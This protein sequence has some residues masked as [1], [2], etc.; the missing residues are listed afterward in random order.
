MTGSD[1]PFAALIGGFMRPV[2]LDLGAI[3]AGTGIRAA[4]FDPALDDL[5]QRLGA[6]AAQA[7]LPPFRAGAP[8]PAVARLYDETPD[9][10]PRHR[11]EAFVQPLADADGAA[12]RSAWPVLH[13]SLARTCRNAVDNL[14]R[15]ARHLAGVPPSWRDLFAIAEPAREL[16]EVVTGLSDPHAGGRTVIRATFESGRRIAYKPRS[17]AAEQAFSRLL[18]ELSVDGRVPDQRAPRVLDAGD[19]GWMEWIE[20][21]PL[22]G[23]AEARS[24]MRRCGGLLAVLHIL[25]GGDIHPDNLLAAG[26]FPVIVD[27]ECLF[28]PS[29]GDLGCIDPLDDPVLFTS[30]IL[31]VFTS[32]DGGANFVPVAGGGAGRPPASPESIVVLANTDWMHLRNRL[33][34]SFPPG[35]VLD[36][37]SLDM[38]DFGA[39]IAAGYD[40]TMAALL[41]RRH[42]LLAEGGA[43]A[44]FRAVPCRM[45]CAPTNLYALVLR[46][47]LAGDASRDI[48]ALAL[49]AGR[50]AGRP[51]L[52]ADR[53]AWQAV[54]DAEKQAMMR[55]DVPAFTFLPDGLTLRSAEGQTIGNV[56]EAPMFDRAAATFMAL[57]ADAAR[58]GAALLEAAL[59]RPP[60]TEQLPAGDGGPRAAPLPRDVLR[61]L[62]DRVASL[63][64]QQGGDA[65]TWIRL[66]EQI[67]APVAPAGPG[68]C[69]GASGTAVFLAEAAGPLDDPQLSALARK[70][71]A[72]LRHAIRRGESGRLARNFGP[73]YGRGIG[74]MIAALGWCGRLLDDPRVIADGLELATASATALDAAPGMADVMDGA[75]GLAL[76]LGALAAGKVDRSHLTDALRLCGDAILAASRVEAQALRHWPER[77]K[78]GLTGLSH[79]TS[80]IAA[81]LMHVHAATADVVWVEAALEALAYEDAQHDPA[82]GTWH[83]GEKRRTAAHG[84]SSWCHG[85]PGIALA[86]SVLAAADSRVAPIRSGMLAALE[87]ARLHPIGDVDDLCCGEAGR[88]ECLAVAAGD[89]PALLQDIDAAIASRL[90]DWSSGRM[91]SLTASAPG[92]PEDASLLRGLAG[93]GHLLVRRIAPAF[94]CPVLMPPPA[95]L[96][97]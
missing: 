25:R 92:A 4:A 89:D 29:P 87:T 69:Y 30:G 91:R 58:S 96:I 51:A 63:A 1:I 39:D 40:A 70:A 61:S 21:E 78:P 76:G 13:D 35:P 82:A 22:A 83:G 32:F 68:L 11:Y 12:L 62:A 54:L 66:W 41:D 56:F 88:L 3:C 53:Q 37:E 27:L 28:Q 84:L 38:R 49:R 72:P 18:A 44:A 80:G 24:F 86:R 17:L 93:P 43:V 95:A 74:G 64:V 19:H 10:A 50:L 31:P 90:P 7:L 73:G 20:P 36:G 34:E 59:R 97:R 46:D 9:E 26:A 77:G 16:T 52:M 14:A 42:D 79:G 55:L 71:L 85:A 47:L 94:A 6:M 57:D 48:D 67:P 5:E 2:R 23:A 15:F 75:A 33:T 45:L 65:V 60:R 8:V 81:A